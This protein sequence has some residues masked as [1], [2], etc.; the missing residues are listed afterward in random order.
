MSNNFNVNE[1]QREKF[2]QL[3][4]VFFTNPKYQSISNDGKIAYAIL[5]DRLNL[6]IKNNW[7][8]ENGDIYFIF[9]NE[10]LKRI[11]NISSPNKLSKIKKELEKADLFSQIRVGLNKPNKLYLKKPVVTQDDIYTIISE[12]NGDDISNDKDV[13]KSYVQTY[14]NHTSRNMKN[15]HQD[16]SKSYANDTDINNTDINNT[17]ISEMNGMSGNNIDNMSEINDHSIHENDNYLLDEQ[18][19]LLKPLPKDLQEF[20]KSRYILADSISI[21]NKI[22]QAKREAANRRGDGLF[23]MFEENPFLSEKIIEIL[24]TVNREMKKKRESVQ[25]LLGYY[26]NSLVNGLEEFHFTEEARKTVQNKVNPFQDN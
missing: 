12:E 23:F 20:I 25:A 3:P 7:V 2:Y 16:V 6:S 11:L 4:K 14:Q 1:V 13:S 8:D 9:T 26:Y 18:S 17:D 21:I 19:H 10:T 22:M 5:R 24:I 15:I